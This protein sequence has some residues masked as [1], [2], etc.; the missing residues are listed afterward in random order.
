LGEAIVAD[1]Y[2]SD[3]IQ[4]I[5]QRAMTMKAQGGEFSRE[6]LLEMAEELGIAP[7]TLQS[8]ERQ[9]RQEEKE[10]QKRRVF[11][12]YR[13]RAFQ[14]HLFAYLLV[15]AFLI[16]LDFGNDGS[17]DWAFWPLLGWGIGVAFD[18]WSTYQTSGAG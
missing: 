10:R 5:L 7:E 2:R 11:R 17:L 15:N 8:A 13:R 4:A 3:E 16:I 14:G 18:A 6:Q 12:T 1:Q 9:W